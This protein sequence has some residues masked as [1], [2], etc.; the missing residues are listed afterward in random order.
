MFEICFAALYEL[1]VMGGE[2]VCESA[3]TI[4]KISSVLIGFTNIDSIE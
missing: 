3:I 2:F 4:N 1:N